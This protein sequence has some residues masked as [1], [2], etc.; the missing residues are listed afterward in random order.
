[1]KKVIVVP[2]VHGRLFW[3]DA[4]DK[5]GEADEIVFLGDYIDPYDY[6]QGALY[7]KLELIDNFKEII[8][9]AKDNSPKVTLL[10]GNHD[11][12]YIS[13]DENIQG[14]RYDHTIKES[15]LRCIDDNTH[16]FKRCPVIGN[17]LF[18]HAGV[19]AGWLRYNGYLGDMDDINEIAS[20]IEMSTIE[21]CAQVGYMRGGFLKSGGPLWADFEEHR[22]EENWLNFDQA[23]GHT[24]CIHTGTVNQ[25]GRVSCYDSRSIHIIDVQV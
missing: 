10:L 21:D 25:A 6:E 13:N 22:N 3:K 14:S 9:F 24:Q 12:H 20:F 2:D 5:A 18:S 7:T 11:A 17:T 1:M 19:T 16:L 4:I 15:F 8:Q 23:V